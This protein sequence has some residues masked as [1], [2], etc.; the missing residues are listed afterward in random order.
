M[1]KRDTWIRVMTGFYAIVLPTVAYFGLKYSPYS[2]V[3]TFVSFAIDLK[4]TRPPN[5]L[6]IRNELKFES[7]FFD[8]FHQKN[9]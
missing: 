1:W 4:D 9:F 5:H 6:R 3:P 8:N 7:F 2:F